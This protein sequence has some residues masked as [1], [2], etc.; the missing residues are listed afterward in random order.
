MYHSLDEG[1]NLTGVVDRVDDVGGELVVIDYKSGKGP[2]LKY[3]ESVNERIMND[4][5]FQLKVYALL[6]RARINR[7][8]TQLQLIYLDG[9][10]KYVMRINEEQVLKAQAELSSQCSDVSK[11]MDDDNF[12]TKP[13]KICNWCSFKSICPAWSR[14]SS[15]SSSSNSAGNG[16]S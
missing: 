11:A 7:L 15:S 16:G 13:G 14:R 6:L 10:T 2:T 8:P 3:S 12:P 4:K 5:F 9:P 1:L